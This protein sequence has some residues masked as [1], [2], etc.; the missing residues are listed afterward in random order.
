M[1]ASPSARDWPTTFMLGFNVDRYGD[2]RQPVL[3]NVI[4]LGVLLPVGSIWAIYRTCAGDTG[5]GVWLLALGLYVFAM[6]GVTLGNH[7]YWTHRGFKVRKPLQ[8]VLAVASA[9]S[10]QGDI[11]Q[12]AL[13][14]RAHHRYPDVV[15]FD[16]HSP[17][18]YREWHGLKGLLWAQIVWVLFQRP[19]AL[20]L[21]PQRDLTEDALVQA[22]R[23]WFPYV[24][25]GQF[26]ALL[27]LF[28]V[29][30]LNAVLIA[31]ALRCTVLLISTGMVNSV[32][33]RWGTRAADSV[34]HEFRSDDSRNNVLV[35]LLAGG[36]G[37]HAWHHADPVC[38]CH[39]RKITLDRSA[40]HAGVRPRH[41]WCPDLTWRAIQLLT[42]LNLV[43]DVRGPCPTMYFLPSQCGSAPSSDTCE[44]DLQMAIDASQSRTG[45]GERGTSVR[46]V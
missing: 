12:W 1:F 4:T 3:A 45:G 38:A 40:V 46:G 34:G 9:L 36:E 29:F 44:A 11:E 5:L 14:H 22:Q 17:L 10:L 18:E 8:Y 23:R 41:E 30:G 21:R 24:A 37:N 25:V 27:A 19:P 2:R 28:P 6:F 32:C 15:G 13:T 39:G 26:P 7:R 43:Y 31:G 20:R 42:L 35:A 16:P 33:H